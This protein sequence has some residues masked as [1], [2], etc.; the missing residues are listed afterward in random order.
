MTSACAPNQGA[1]A[2][3]QSAARLVRSGAWSL[4]VMLETLP[5]VAEIAIVIAD[6]LGLP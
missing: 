3:G 1:A 2:D 5:A 6:L 4:A